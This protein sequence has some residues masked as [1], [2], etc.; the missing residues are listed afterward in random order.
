MT[1]KDFIEIMNSDTQFS[2]VFSDLPEAIM[3]FRKKPE[4]FENEI[5][6]KQINTFKTYYENYV[7]RTIIEIEIK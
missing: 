6:N 4:N 5:F 1:L 7:E 2:I 3:I